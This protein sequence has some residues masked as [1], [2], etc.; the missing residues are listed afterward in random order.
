MFMSCPYR[1]RCWLIGWALLSCEQS[2]YA[3][4]DGV[5]SFSDLLFLLLLLAS[6]VLVLLLGLALWRWAWQ[7][8]A[9]VDRR[10]STLDGDPVQPSQRSSVATDL[11]KTTSIASEKSNETYS[12]DWRTLF[13]R[14]SLAFLAIVFVVLPS[15]LLIDSV[16]IWW[17]HDPSV[18]TFA[19]GP[20]MFLCYLPVAVGLLLRWRKDEGW[21]AAALMTIAFAW[22]LFAVF[23]PLNVLQINLAAYSKLANPG[24]LEYLRL[25]L[26][27]RQFQLMIAALVWLFATSMLRGVP[28]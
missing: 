16:V 13:D 3:A 23:T 14:A 27:M 21:A 18:M 22:I 8:K 9:S 24:L 2:T 12:S 28:R 4:A 10:P 1:L 5:E 25:V 17:H 26:P 7:Q 11:E 15:G 20:G 19:F 6:P